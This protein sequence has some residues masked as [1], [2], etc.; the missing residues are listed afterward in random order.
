MKG[1]ILGK[2]TFL[3]RFANFK[4]FVAVNVIFLLKDGEDIGRACIK[5][6]NCLD[7]R[8]VVHL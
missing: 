7:D 6:V 4:T 8:R 2:L 3:N 5:V 1:I